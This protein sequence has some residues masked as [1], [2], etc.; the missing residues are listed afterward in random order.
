[1]ALGA[2]VH[3]KMLVGGRAQRAA[4]DGE[5]VDKLRHG[6]FELADEDTA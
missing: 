3:E 1:M 2:R 6:Q 5:A 4:H